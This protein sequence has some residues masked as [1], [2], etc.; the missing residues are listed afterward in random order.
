M[1]ITGQYV[2]STDF[3]ERRT[4]VRVV[5]D[6]DELRDRDADEHDSDGESDERENETA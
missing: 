3:E 4:V 1:T 2:P 5:E 6:A